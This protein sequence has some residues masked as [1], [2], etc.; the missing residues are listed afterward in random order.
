MAKIVIIGGGISGLAAAEILGRKIGKK[1]EILVLEKQTDFT[2]TASIPW[3]LNKKRQLSE[4][5]RPY[6]RRKN[7]GSALTQCEVTHIDFDK[8][9]VQTD[10]NDFSYD[11]LMIAPG[12]AYF[13]D[14]LQGFTQAAVSLYEP[15]QAERIPALASESSIKKIVILISSLPFKCPAAPYE[16]AFLLRD[17]LGKTGYQPAI[18]IVTPEMLPMPVAGESVGKNVVSLLLSRGITFSPSLKAVSIDHERK[19]ISFENG[20]PKTYDLLLGIPPHGLPQFLAGSQVVGASGWIEVD[21]QT[22]QTK[23]PKVFASGDV[24]SIPLPSGK[25]LP[26]AGVFARAQGVVI[27]QN[28]ISAVK[29]EKMNKTFDGDGACFLEIGGGR[30]G[31]ASGNFFL[32]T[33]AIQ[34]KEPSRIWHWGKV[35]FEKWFLR[36][37]FLGEKK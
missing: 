6:S 22:L 24:T 35:L 14:K 10:K 34:M 27:A 2:F 4:I 21:A 13:P 9:I 15:A 20:E 25:P 12:A 8:K 32:P 37:Y 30:A 28:I 1:H 11:F 17:F 16:A 36:N 19:Q 31:Y 33:G 5:R 29:G 3:L 7:S 26:K 23:I 18:E